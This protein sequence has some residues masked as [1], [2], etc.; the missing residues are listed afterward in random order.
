MASPVI[1][2]RSSFHCLCAG[3]ISFSSTPFFSPFLCVDQRLAFEKLHSSSLSLSLSYRWLILTR[4]RTRVQRGFEGKG[5]WYYCLK[6]QF[7]ERKLYI[8]V[9]PAYPW[10]TRQFPNTNAI[11]ITCLHGS[12]VVILIPFLPSLSS[13]PYVR[14][15]LGDENLTPCI[16]A[17]DTCPPSRKTDKPQGGGEGFAFHPVCQFFPSDSLGKSTLVGVMAWKIACS[18]LLGNW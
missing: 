16:L 18:I 10:E 1:T 11:L 2:P 14:R 6:K 17:R 5:E 13:P 9:I 8:S 12:N 3:I 15:R 7:F 4:K